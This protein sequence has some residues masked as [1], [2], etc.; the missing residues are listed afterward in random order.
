MNEE[1]QRII[2]SMVAA[3][4]SED[5]IRL[6]IEN[7]QPTVSEPEVET[8]GAVLEAVNVGISA[9]NPIAGAGMSLA[10]GLKVGGEM[11]IGIAKQIPSGQLLMSSIDSNKRIE[12]SLKHIEDMPD[13]KTIALAPYQGSN[14]SRSMMGVKAE[15]KTVKEWKEEFN[16]VT[17][18]NISIGVNSM[19]ELLE[20]TSKMNKDPNVAAD[21]RQIKSPNDL[22]EFI[23][24]GVGQAAP[25]AILSLITGGGFSYLMESTMI[26]S[27]AV[28]KLIE[29]GYSPEEAMRKQ[30]LNT[31]YAKGFGA[32]AAALDLLSLSVL[33]KAMGLGVV[34]KEIAKSLTKAMIKRSS[35]KETAKAVATEFVT[36]PTQGFLE[37]IGSAKVRGL[38]ARE[39]D[40]DPIGYLSEGI[41]AAI[42]I[43]ALGVGGKGLSSFFNQKVQNKKKESILDAIQSETA[44][45]REEAEVMLTQEVKRIKDIDA[46]TDI[47][48]KDT[49]LNEV[50]E[51]TK[52]VTKEL[53]TTPEIEELVQPLEEDIASF[54][55][56]EKVLGVEEKRIGAEKEAKV[57]EKEVRKA[58][59]VH[60]KELGEVRK[61]EEKEATKLAKLL[62]IERAKTA[63]E[64][65]QRTTKKAS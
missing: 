61:G 7:F 28:Q 9:I 6:V 64:T 15:F 53:P 5:N 27:D 10:R 57:A 36:E 41:S 59:E 30:M 19:T 65:K 56:E 32:G 1:L 43:F 26:M 29:D 17:E 14:L 54:L 34:K 55:E 11:A 24:T 49:E 4:E 12:E 8:S 52:E 51:E 50:L 13:D 16:R 3:G 21:I 44:L 37:D 25:Q 38:P 58:K 39:G 2:T 20:L 42:G 45:T 22:V 23:G 33:A 18:D 31:D 40:Y 46:K 35:R 48:T 60:R 47:T 62:D 63:K